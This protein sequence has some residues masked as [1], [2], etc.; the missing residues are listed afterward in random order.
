MRSGNYF[1]SFV[2][3]PTPVKDPPHTCE[4]FLAHPISN[5]QE[6]LEEE[7]R[8]LAMQRWV[9]LQGQEAGYA[10]FYKCT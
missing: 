9:M 1:C 4:I 7:E 3:H 10:S 6:A 5:R 2:F 8:D